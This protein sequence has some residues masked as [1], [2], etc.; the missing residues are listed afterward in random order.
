MNHSF[1]ISL[2]CQTFVQNFLPVLQ[3]YYFIE[4]TSSY[5]KITAALIFYHLVVF[6]RLNADVMINH[7]L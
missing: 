1:H 5:A 3:N 2:D 7:S 6:Y 4:P